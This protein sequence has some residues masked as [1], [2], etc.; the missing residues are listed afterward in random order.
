MWLTVLSIAV[1]VALDQLSKY[2]ATA[3][4]Q[5]VGTLPFLPGVMQLT[6][7]LND[8]AAFSI[9]AGRQG[10]LIAVTTAALAV[11]LALLVLGK[12]ANA[13]TRW[14]LTLIV[15]GGIGNLIDRVLHGVVVDFFDVTFMQYAIFNVADCFVTVGCV[16]LFVGI[17]FAERLAARCHAAGDGAA[18]PQ[19]QEEKQ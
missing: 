5:P 2:W 3:V 14:G 7:A 4:L 6:Y 8:G 18:Q 15:G 10:L 11:M 1:L 9:F 12:T 17:L 16:L 19:K 13:L